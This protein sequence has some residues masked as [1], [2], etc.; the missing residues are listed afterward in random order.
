MSVCLFTT[1]LNGMS[2]LPLK[3]R[4]TKHAG[5]MTLL[6]N[7]TS[8]VCVT[9][10]RSVVDCTFLAGQFVLMLQALSAEATPAT[11]HNA[12]GTRA[13]IHTVSSCIAGFEWSQHKG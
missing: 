6:Q 7:C 10:S 8:V 4:E 11:L 2:D 13:A 12:N 9:P 3:L 5:S 1:P